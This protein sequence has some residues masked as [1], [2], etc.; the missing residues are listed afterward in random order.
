[1]FL[2]IAGLLNQAD[3]GIGFPLES[4][5]RKP[6]NQ[7]LLKLESEGTLKRLKTKWWKQKR[8]GGACANW[9]SL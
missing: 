4:I 6:I 8:G 1:M 5:H 9:V 3:Y 2:S 7:A